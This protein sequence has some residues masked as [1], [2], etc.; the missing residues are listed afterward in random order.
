MYKIGENLFEKDEVSGLR[1]EL[2]MLVCLTPESIKSGV[3]NLLDFLVSVFCRQVTNV[4][5]ADIFDK[6]KQ[7]SLINSFV[8]K[9]LTQVAI[10]E[11]GQGLT[12]SV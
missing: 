5:Q 8:A 2:P 12:F 3:E 6:A 4:F 1:V 11:S 7:I 9:T 10:E